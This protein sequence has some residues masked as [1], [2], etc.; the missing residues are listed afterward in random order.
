VL[1]QTI[2]PGTAPATAELAEPHVEPLPWA[3]AGIVTAAAGLWIVIALVAVAHLKEAG[4][5]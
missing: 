3:R 4:L 5:W 2:E 1:H